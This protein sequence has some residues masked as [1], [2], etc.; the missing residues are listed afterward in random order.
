MDDRTFLILLIV[1]GV[2]ALAIGW[3]VRRRRFDMKSIAALH[4]VA[5]SVAVGMTMGEPDLGLDCRARAPCG[6]QGPEPGNKLRLYEQVRKRGVGFVRALRSQHD[7]GIDQY[8]HNIAQEPVLGV[9]CAAPEHDDRPD[10]V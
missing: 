3:L 10:P 4:V 1:A 8:A 7:L 2:L 6:Q 5:A 9:E